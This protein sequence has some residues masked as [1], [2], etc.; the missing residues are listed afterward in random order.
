MLLEEYIS[1]VLKEAFDPS[2]LSKVV[3]ALNDVVEE[4]SLEERSYGM[5]YD[6]VKVPDAFGMK[7]IGG[8]VFRNAYVLSGQDWVLKLAAGDDGGG[9]DE[10]EMNG[11]EVSIARG[12]HGVGP[13]D[14]FVDM[15]EYDMISKV[16]SWLITQRVMTLGKASRVLS[17]NDLSQIFPTFYNA[18][19]DGSRLKSSSQSFCD[20][21]SDV[22]FELSIEASAGQNS[23][24]LSREEF[25]SFFK[26]EAYFG[27]GDS[28]G[29]QAKSYDE[30]EFYDDFVRIARACAYSRPDDMH[31]GNIGIVPSDNVGP[32][33]IVI[34]DYMLDY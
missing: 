24:G 27:S 18:L 1:E 9:L 7:K 13:Q 12:D 10:R 19:K 30:I 4:Y 23:S 32:K 22:L 29:N 11:I 26:E 8:G 34:L 31:D 6:L 25:Y 15:Y 5:F 17:M 33:D 21:I 20:L 16:P 3:K 2:I 28:R 14:L